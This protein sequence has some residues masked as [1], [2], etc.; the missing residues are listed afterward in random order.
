MF[1]VV[2]LGEEREQ[3]EPQSL[4]PFIPFLSAL[5][6]WGVFGLARLLAWFAH[7]MLE[8]GCLLFPPGRSFVPSLPGGFWP[9]MP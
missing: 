4:S 8:V 9:G 1:E 6:R 3:A 5:S 2:S 7:K